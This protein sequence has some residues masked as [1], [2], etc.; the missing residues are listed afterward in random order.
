[1]AKKRTSSAF[2]VKSLS[3]AKVKSNDLKLHHGRVHYVKI[4]SSRAKVKWT[5]SKRAE[6]LEYVNYVQTKLKLMDWEIT[7][8]F[9]EK[10]ESG[11]VA[12]MIPFENQKKAVLQ[13][14][15]SFL[16]QTDS[17]V[18][19]TIVHELMHCHLFALQHTTEATIESL[20]G[21]KAL[22][23]FAPALNSLIESVTD[24]LADAF[25][26]LIDK[27]CRL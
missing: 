7:V 19:Q 27:N 4:P 1:M 6:V 24:V 12:T 18:R 8:N 25:T 21:N 2:N 15:D 16:Q 11:A 9:S 17:E 20:S 10:S 14:G 26:P 23:A 3:S 22:A 13:F 5:A